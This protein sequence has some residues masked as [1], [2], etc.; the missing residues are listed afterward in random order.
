MKERTN[1]FIHLMMLLLMVVACTKEN[2]E[3]VNPLRQDDY[4]SV[5]MQVPGMKNATTR[6]EE[7]EDNL[8]SVW[9]LVF[10]DGKL[11][12]KTEVSTLIPSTST[13]GTFNLSRPK[14]DDVIHFLGNVPNDVTLPDVGDDESALC[15]LE[16]DDRE[17]LSYWG[18]A[19]YNGG[20]I[21][22]NLYRHLAKIEIA[23]DPNECTFPEDQLF[24]AGLVNA[25]QTGALIPNEEGYF[26]FDCSEN[27]YYTLPKNPDPLYATPL[28]SNYNTKMDNFVYVFEHDNNN[29]ETPNTNEALYVICKIG[30]SYYKV[31]LVNKEGEPYDIIRNHKY[32]IY[33]QD[34]DEI[35]Y[36]VPVDI[37]EK[38][39]IENYKY[40]LAKDSVPINLTVIETKDVVFSPN[41]DQTINLNGYLDVQMNAYDRTLSTLSI[42][43]DG[44]TVSSTNGS[45]S[46]PTDNVYTY[47]GGS[48]TFRFTPNSLGTKTIS[49]YNGQGE[50][51]S[52]PE[53]VFNV[54]VQGLISASADKTD[55]YYNATTEQTVTVTVSVPAGVENLTIEAQE[56]GLGG[57]T[58]GEYTYAMNSQ[59]NVS[60]T[61]TLLK[62]KVSQNEHQSY[63]TIKDAGGIAT[64]RSVPINVKSVPTVSFSDPGNQTLYWNNGNPTSFQVQMTDVPQN[65]SVTVNITG[66]SAFTIT[67]ANSNVLQLNGD[68]YT[69][70]GGNTTFTIKPNSESTV[71]N[72]YNIGFSG[73]GTDLIVNSRNVQVTVNSSNSEMSATSG[74]IDMGSDKNFV[75]LSLTKPTN[76]RS[77][78]V[79]FDSE[80]FIINDNPYTSNEYWVHDND[81]AT[82]DFKFSLENNAAPGTYN[83]IFYGS[84]ENKEYTAT[85]TITV[86]NT[87]SLQFEYEDNTTLYLDG[88]DGNPTTLPIT[89]I[90]PVGSTLAE[91]N[92]S[93]DGF[94]IKQ[95][96]NT[97]SDNG[98]YSY[99]SGTST[100]FT[101]IPQSIG[102][103]IIRFSG[104]NE[105]LIVDKEI[106]VTVLPKM[107]P[108]W[109]GEEALTESDKFQL[110]YDLIKDYIGKTIY[111]DFETYSGG[112]RKL[113]LRSD[114]N[115]LVEYNSLEAG[116]TMTRDVLMD[117][118]KVVENKNIIIFGNAV[119]VRRIYYI[120]SE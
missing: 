72:S 63:I 56:F 70:T 32:T 45:L 51:L 88:G 8:T 35:E 22:V 11:V 28:L 107:I 106:S 13:T 84:V 93:A 29:P 105:N 62:D 15:N 96:D 1:I 42:S 46:G 5:R 98:S 6:A 119:T 34:F 111:V 91:L 39:D 64:Q 89:I 59:T 52:V 38:W 86:K 95:G 104:T 60:L 16:T 94:I 17:N 115:T 25:N 54:N 77:I 24:I 85:A 75:I 47:T 57:D 4:V 113:A 67:D 92:I 55:L 61:F 81:N 30:E 102:D 14:V 18:K 68:T 37:T 65:G 103:K 27:D 73:S 50:Y 99:T 31:A 9:A 78:K 43:A 80:T 58:D 109:S 23:P 10:R 36:E 120:P 40:D 117:S 41:T 114:N 108:I 74:T 12:S 3:V 87:P 26:N 110:S 49:F 118:N 20:D 116:K 112:Y 33:V 83:V 82:I 19:T 66:A 21:T 71:G 101:F 69:Y 48:T 53:T 44:F 97:L 2:V 76:I 90:V 7:A 79:T 100:T